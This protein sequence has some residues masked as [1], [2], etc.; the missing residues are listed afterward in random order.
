MIRVGEF[1]VMFIKKMGVGV[2]LKN[3]NAYSGEQNEKDIKKTGN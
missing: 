3:K 2:G 1:W